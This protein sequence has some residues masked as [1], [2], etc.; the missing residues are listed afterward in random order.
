[1]A[2]KVQAFYGIRTVGRNQDQWEEAME[3]QSPS[4]QGR[5]F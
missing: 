5:T 2:E 4:T 1:M 3:W